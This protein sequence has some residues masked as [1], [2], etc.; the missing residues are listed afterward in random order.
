MFSGDDSES[1]FRPG[2]E[3]LLEELA[4]PAVREHEMHINLPFRSAADA[5]AF[6]SRVR[7]GRKVLQLQQ[8]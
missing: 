8:I 3:V 5:M 6:P 1:V 4:I 2:L 7:R